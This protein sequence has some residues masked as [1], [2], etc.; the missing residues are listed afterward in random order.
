MK[1]SRKSYSVYLSVFLL[2][3]LS[4]VFLPLDVFHNHEPFAV[5]KTIK[6]INS[7]SKED[8]NAKNSADYCWVCAVHIDKTFTKANFVE[9]LRL[10]PAMSVF[11]NNEI[12]GY[13]VELL[14]TS[15]RGPPSE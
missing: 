8:L 13:V 12:T 4:A 5:N 14:L 6:Q 1:K 3:A 15:L 9:K 11:L 7:S 10:S 2:I